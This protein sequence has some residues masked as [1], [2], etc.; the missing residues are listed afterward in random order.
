MKTYLSIASG[1]GGGSSG[2]SKHFTGVGAVDNWDRAREYHALNFPTVPTFDYDLK[3][4]LASQLPSADIILNSCPCTEI[5]NANKN[6]NPFGDL[7]AMLLR[8]IGFA[9]FYKCMVLENVF[10]L[11]QKGQMEI[12]YNLMKKEYAKLTDYNVVD[13]VLDSVHY[14]T[15]QKRRRY[16]AI[17]LHKDYGR[18]TLPPRTTTDYQALKLM[19]VAPHLSELRTGYHDENYHYVKMKPRFP[20]NYCFTVTAGRNLFDQNDTLLD[21]PTILRLCG[22][23]ADWVYSHDPK[24]HELM[25]RLAGN[26]IM[27]PFGEAIAAHLSRTLS[28]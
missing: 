18:P 5:S 2:F 15:P 19:N 8:S 17:I 1:W 25:W 22:Y 3:T 4:V 24:D 16:I 27:P 14:N 26:S 11:K 10:A 6:A 23:P 20:D 21:I 12:L 13:G 9:K 28:I 7:N